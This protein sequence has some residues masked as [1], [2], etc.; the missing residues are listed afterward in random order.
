[1]KTCYGFWD[2]EPFDLRNASLEELPA[3]LNIE[4]LEF[5]DGSNPVDA[6]VSHRGF[7]IFN[8]EVSLIKVLRDYWEKGLREFLRQSVLPCRNGTAL[9]Y[10]LLKKASGDKH[11]LSEKDWKLIEEVCTLMVESS[12]CGVGQTVPVSLIGALKIFSLKI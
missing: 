10:D 9:V 3:T 8:P 7:I 4:E 11:S 6:F 1:M 5:F 12:F 2:G